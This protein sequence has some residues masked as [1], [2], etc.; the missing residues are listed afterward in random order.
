MRIMFSTIQK[1]QSLN[2]I[3]V[4]LNQSIYRIKAQAKNQKPYQDKIVWNQT[5]H[6][7]LSIS[8]KVVSNFKV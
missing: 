4:K 5:R 6:A 7:K 8:L 2:E 3:E 1:I